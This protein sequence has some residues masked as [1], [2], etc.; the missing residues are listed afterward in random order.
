MQIE[1]IEKAI[2]SNDGI[3]VKIIS[4]ATKIEN[5]AKL[6]PEI[7]KRM[8]D[9]KLDKRWRYAYLLDNINDLNP[10]IV[11]PYLPRI[12]KQ[13]P[14][15]TNHSLRRHFVRIINKHPIPKNEDL[16]NILLEQCF[17]FL[18][19]AKI[20]VAVKAHCISICTKLC[21]IYPEL[22]GEFCSILQE[23]MEKNTSAFAVR[24]REVLNRF[25]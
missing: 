7:Y 21:L 6:L 15:L 13:L 9:E 2:F 14:K 17:N 1:D 24:A 25:S 19:D 8:L 3:R 5:N 23:E 22:K 11:K 12:I 20:K 10:K 18:Q 16:Q 4:V